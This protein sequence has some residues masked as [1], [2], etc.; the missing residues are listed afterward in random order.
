MAAVHSR[1]TPIL[2]AGAVQLTTVTPLTFKFGSKLH[3]S[4]AQLALEG[5]EKSMTPTM[6]TKSGL[7]VFEDSGTGG[8][9]T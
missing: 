6:G 5:G 4:T 2:G 3:H 8:E 9:V 1:L 7:L